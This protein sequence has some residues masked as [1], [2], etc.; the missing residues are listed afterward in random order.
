[1]DAL[2]QDL[3][4]SVRRLSRS[5]GFTL[6][7]VVTLALGIGA[8]AAIFSFV[9]ALI[10]KPTAGLRDPERVVAIFT[11]DFSSSDYSS[12]SYPDFEDFR[13]QTDVFS[14]AAAKLSVPLNVVRGE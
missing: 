7:A 6:I 13:A 4:Y 9:N 5:P 1:M 11:S 10:L 12:S 14:G 8:N 2:L 3:R